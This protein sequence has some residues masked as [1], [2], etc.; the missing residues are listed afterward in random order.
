MEEEAERMWGKEIKRK[1]EPG[2]NQRKKGEGRKRE[3]RG[4]KRKKKLKGTEMKNTDERFMQEI[5]R[6]DCLAQVFGGKRKRHEKWTRL[7][8]R[9]HEK[10]KHVS[11][12][13]TCKS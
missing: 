1:E 13:E 9:D 3:T 2:R 11:L 7:H 8:L 10:K 5:H 6:M 4:K 12:P